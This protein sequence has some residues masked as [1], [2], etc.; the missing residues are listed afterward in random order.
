M[1]YWIME[2]FFLLC[3]VSLF[4]FGLVLPHTGIIEYGKR[5]R[6]SQYKQK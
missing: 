4:I 5:L 2:N 6:A 1:W 3:F